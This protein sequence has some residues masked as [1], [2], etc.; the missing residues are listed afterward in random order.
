MY[1]LS[2]VKNIF[3]LRWPL[4]VKV[5]PWK[6]W[7]QISQKRYEI[8][9]KSQWKLDRKSCMGFRMGKI[10]F[11]SGDLSK[12]QRSRSNSQKLRNTFILVYNRYTH[13]KPTQKQWVVPRWLHWLLQCALC[14]YQTAKA[15]TLGV[16]IIELNTGA[17][18]YV[19]YYYYISE[20]NHQSRWKI[21][22]KVFL[23]KNIINSLLKSD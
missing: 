18:K 17:Y 2:N 8:E 19:Y 4:K 1:G 15:R 23:N 20:R 16:Y 13:L 6:L 21:L 12:S 5:K 22:P 3:D 7:S 14:C 9:R 11:I 10:I